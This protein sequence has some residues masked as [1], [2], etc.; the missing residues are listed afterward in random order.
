MKFGSRWGAHGEF[1]MFALAASLTI[2]EC[3][4]QTQTN[5]PAKAPHELQEIERVHHEYIM[6]H[7]AIATNTPAFDEYAFKLMLDEAERVTSSWKL[8]RVPPLTVQNVTFDAIATPR[9]VTGGIATAD[10]RFGWSFTENTLMNFNERAYTPQSFEYK[11]SESAQ[12]AKEKSKITAKEAEAMARG[13]LHA[14]GLSEQRLDLV[15][16]PKVEQ[17]T[18]MDTQQVIHPLPIFKVVWSV[19]GWDEPAPGV[20]FDISGVTGQ[21]AQYI[22]TA[23]DR[24]QFPV[25]SNYLDMLDILPPTNRAQ[26]AGIQFWPHK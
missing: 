11:E 7:L 14:I 19:R 8:E 4:G 25:P 22:N 20:R 6:R 23:L 12:L 21:V 16:P 17:Y 3:D 24:P 10:H 15:Q 13:Y 5:P 18:F 9:G 2:A 1:K 26:K